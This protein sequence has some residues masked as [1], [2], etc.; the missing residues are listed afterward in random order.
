MIITTAGG[1]SAAGLTSS[2]AGSTVR[3][4]AADDLQLMG[5]VLSG[6]T[7]SQQLNGAGKRIGESFV[8][9]PKPSEIVVS[10]GGQAWI[11][12]MTTNRAGDLV[13]TGGTLRTT[14]RV[15][16]TGGLNPAGIGVLVSGASEVSAVNAAGSIEMNSTGDA[17]IQG[18][19]LAG[20]LVERRYDASGE[21]LGR[22]MTI[23]NGEST[24]KITADDQIRVGQS[25]QAGAKIELVGGDDPVVAGQT[26]SGQ[27]LL[28]LGSVQLRTWRPNSQIL[29][30][31]PGPLSIL[32][33]AHLKEIAA[34][35]FIQTA[36]G[37][38][39]SDVTLNLKLDR[40]AFIAEAAVTITAAQAADNL[41]IEDLMA[42]L[43]TAIDSASW[44]V[45]SSTTADHPVGSNWSSDPADPDFDVKLR[46][47]RLLLTSA[48]DFELAASSTAAGL[49]GFQFTAS[50]PLTSVRPWS[51]LADE[52]GATVILGAPGT[53]SGR[54]YV[55]GSIFADAGIQLRSGTAADIADLELA[56]TGVLQT[57]NASITLSPGAHGVIL[58]DVIAGGPNSDL[59]VNSEQS[60]NIYGTLKA[61]RDLIINAGSTLIPGFVSLQTHGTSRLQALGSAGRILLTG[62]NDVRLNSTIGGDSPQLS[63]IQLVSEQGTV[64]VEKES[65]NIQAGARLVFSGNDVDLAGVV[66]STYRT[67]DPDDFEVL[68][69][70]DGLA[71]LRGDLSL[72]GSLRVNAG[73][74][75]VYDTELEVTDPAQKLEFS[76]GGDIRFGRIAIADGHASLPDGQAYIE[77]ARVRS[78]N[79]L[80]LTADGAIVISSGSIVA[81]SDDN[82][83]MDVTAGEIS[84]VGSL[85]SGAAWDTDRNTTWTGSNA[86]L[87]V[88][89]T[90]SLVI[91][92]S[93]IDDAGNPVQRGG[94]LQ[95]TGLLTVNAGNLISTALSTL[96]ADA[97][98]NGTL[99]TAVPANLVITVQDASLDGLT[100]AI[101][102]G[103][104]IQFTGTGLLVINGLLRADA[105]VTV[106]GGSDNSGAG[107]VL[108]P[109][110]LD[111]SDNRISGG[112]ITVSP[113]GTISVSAIDDIV[114][115]GVL[116]DVDFGSDGEILPHA[117]LLTANSLH[118]S[119][120]VT[121]TVEARENLVLQGVDVNVLSGGS[122]QTRSE[123]SELLLRSSGVVYVS[124]AAVDSAGLV[125]ANGMVHLLGSTVQAD[126]SVQAVGTVHE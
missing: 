98:G 72:T 126:G 104:T 12:G 50:Q 80:S 46:D 105:S 64:L 82:G 30:N 27:G 54:I 66:S 38:L 34:A 75:A 29:L 112:V 44:T 14:N 15:L 121:G 21:Y 81:V 9:S 33:P 40:V 99:V 10:A 2:A 19:I 107:L 28:L 84:I 42:D 90:D 61:G 109:I 93:G 49:L 88:T 114:I 117:R 11:G 52:P 24:L 86:V 60:L 95:S 17:D 36:N 106:A 39:S 59:I 70:I 120:T 111:S 102:P 13:E 45:V 123:N 100:E 110:F 65:G 125:R 56:A 108:Q 51:L 25:L 124:E 31:A 22:V 23:A 94:T 55:A 71:T 8:W 16:V 18:A 26:Y 43:Q 4:A 118:G 115:A 76:S 20:G 37:R 62:V 103:G 119:V 63:L 74:I 47:S 35:N 1:V 53:A 85:F 73:D 122:V 6:G 92:G 5:N 3:I 78:G 68:V 67:A 113:A 89:A 97:T 7:M 57:G 32:A 69:D 91:G 41:A 79:S 77:G 101:N 96:R 58:G 87:N 116:G 83:R 48:W